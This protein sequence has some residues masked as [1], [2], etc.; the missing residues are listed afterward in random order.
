M[1][2]QN[3]STLVLFMAAA[4][5]IGM[6]IVLLSDLYSDENLATVWKVVWLP[7]LV[8]LP[9]LGGL[10]YGSV[11]LIRSLAGLRQRS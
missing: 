9:L 11:S 10:L 7:V 6:L 2:P 5:W 4:A 3:V 8:C 1:D